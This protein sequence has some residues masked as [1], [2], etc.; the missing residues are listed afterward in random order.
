M[1]GVLGCQ[2]RTYPFT[3]LGLPTGTMKPKVEDFTPLVNKIERRI[4]AIVT[5]LTMAGRA[6]L[7]AH[8]HHVQHQDA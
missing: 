3:Y 8:L 7:V 5:W 4:S 1:A 2:V 6:T